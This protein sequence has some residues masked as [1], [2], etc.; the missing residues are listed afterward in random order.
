M[1]NK[2]LLLPGLLVVSAL[3]VAL[4]ILLGLQSPEQPVPAAGGQDVAGGAKPAAPVKAETSSFGSS[5]SFG[6]G[7]GFGGVSRAPAPVESEAAEIAEVPLQP[8]EQAINQILES[9]EANFQAAARLGS[10]LPTLPL[11]GQVEAA[12]HMVNLTDDENYQTASAMVLNP[13]TPSDV[14]DVVFADA[15]NRPNS[16]KL[17]LLVAILR[18][19]GHRQRTEALST[20]QVFTGEDLGD[21]PEAWNAYVQNFL[22][23]EAREEAA[24]GQNQ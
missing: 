19:P 4:I 14:V 9:D 17:P 13:A 5:S 24:A 11:E 18:V 21:N 22:A 20:L 15:L 8:W 23:N 10:L 3:V 1:L 12:Q 7:S 2:S 6:G 16:I